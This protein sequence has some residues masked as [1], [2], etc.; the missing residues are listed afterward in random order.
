MRGRAT[1]SAHRANNG[2]HPTHRR[3]GREIAKR[4]VGYRQM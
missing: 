3:S 4:Y 1:S 2:T